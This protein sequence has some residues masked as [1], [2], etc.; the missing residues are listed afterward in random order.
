MG[1]LLEINGLNVSFFTRLGNIDAV[2]NVSIRVETGEVLGLVG[3]SGAG[4][5]TIGNAIINLIEPPG[6][7]TNGEVLFQGENLSKL[8]ENEMLNIRGKK[9]GMIF[10]NPQTSL[11]PVRTIGTQ[12]LETISTTKNLFG[13]LAYQ[14][15]VDL[16]KSVKIEQ[17][18]ARMKAYPHQFSGGMRQRVV[19]ALALAGDPDLI[20]ADEPTTALDVSTQAQILDLIKALCK[21]RQLGVIIVTH[22]LA[23]VSNIADR[24]AVMFRGSIVETGEVKKT[25][26]TPE[27]HYTKSLLAA[28]PR[29]DL[30]MKRFTS[31]DYIEGSTP[32]KKRIAVAEHWLGEKLADKRPKMAMVITN[33]NKKFV[34]KKALFKKHRLYNHAVKDVSFS[35]KTGETFGLV[36][37][38]G[39]GKSTVARLVA[40]LLS[41]DGGSVKLFDKETANK[42][43]DKKVV[44][45][46]RELQMI[47]QDPFSSLN[48]K[49]SVED[50]I[51]EPIRYYKTASSEY[52]LKQIVN[53]LLYHVGLGEKAL[54]KYPHEFSGGQR[55]RISIAR[56]LAA[57]PKILICDEP[58]SSL[59]VSV[60][61]HILNLLKDLQDELELT[62]LFISHDLPVIR[63]MCDRV[64]V[65]R[66]GSICEIAETNDLFNKPIHAYSKHLLKL[67]PSMD[68]LLRKTIDP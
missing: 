35:I 49:M 62:M 46:Q 33:L 30:K 68:L 25:L 45:A 28:V 56:A 34:L 6:K 5:S 32:V 1:K 3:E 27:H 63:Q 9:I 55:Q 11:N 52:Q 40:G 13:K 64:A 31:V 44:A 67:M 54:K 36:G 23:V 60:Q 2:R 50:I 26:S 4:K 20:I 53:D 19:I 12:L 41:L 57:R 43:T 37:E 29:S 10:Q 15:A 66:Y 14:K 61:A 58:T 39:S 16:L 47:F 17:P 59:D 22:D 24:I 42:S 48:S 21:E 51:S 38:S 8:N 7:I 65:M 18:E